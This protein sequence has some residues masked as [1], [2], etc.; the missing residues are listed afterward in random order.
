VL[1]LTEYFP[2]LLFTYAQQD[3]T[4][5]SKRSL[6]D[7]QYRTKLEKQAAGFNPKM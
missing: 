4:L 7:N 5:K 3:G 6:L 2:V 1:R